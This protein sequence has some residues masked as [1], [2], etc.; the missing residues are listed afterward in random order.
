MS[1]YHLTTGILVSILMAG[2]YP[3]GHARNLLNGEVYKANQVEFIKAFLDIF[4]GKKDKKI[5]APSGTE[6][7]R[8]R[9]CEI[10]PGKNFG[11]SEPLIN[12]FE[13]R[14]LGRDKQ[15]LNLMQGFLETFIM[16]ESIGQ[17]I[18][19]IISIINEDAKIPRDIW[20]SIS[21]DQ[22]IPISK[23]SECSAVDPAYFFCAAY[24]LSLKQ[25]NKTG[26]GTFLT[27]FENKNDSQ[28]YELKKGVIPDN[29]VEILQYNQKA[30]TKK[31]LP[32][33]VFI[34]GPRDRMDS[35]SSQSQRSEPNKQATYYFEVNGSNAMFGN[36]IA[37][38]TQN[39]YGSKED[40]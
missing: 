13:K 15:T 4:L 19:L 28:Q 14:V 37:N 29:K 9:K 24:L 17:M 6:I 22:I 40:E 36:Q 34:E 35:K 26:T 1:E 5:T 39:N 31:P 3:S 27:F 11:F 8:F 16:P 20:I 23:I 32:P 33:E 21:C 25:A 2:R 30:R 38:F 7:T 10:E 12:E 18:S